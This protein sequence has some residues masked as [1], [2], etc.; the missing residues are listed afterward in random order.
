MSG[1]G[2]AAPFTNFVESSISAGIDP[3]RSPIQY[4]IRSTM[5]LR[6]FHPVRP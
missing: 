3:A 5:R 4:A 2:P 6:P 1:E